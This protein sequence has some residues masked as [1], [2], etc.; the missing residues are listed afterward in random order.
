MEL[1]LD[2]S[3]TSS[4]YNFFS[5]VF[6]LRM[7]RDKL[8]NWLYDKSLT[9]K[10]CTMSGL[11]V[12]W[13]TRRHLYISIKQNILQIIFLKFFFLL[14]LWRFCELL[15][16]IEGVR[17]RKVMLITR[18]SYQVERMNQTTVRETRETRERRGQITHYWWLF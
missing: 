17:Y 14:F 5:L 9:K 4:T 16:S 7:P 13:N 18:F 1:S 11:Y 12:D 8:C 15:R 10:Y 3:K 6:V 2:V